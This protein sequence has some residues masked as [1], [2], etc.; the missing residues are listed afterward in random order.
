MGAVMMYTHDYH[1]F[2]PPN[3][4]SS[5]APSGHVWVIGHAAALPDAT[6][7][8]LLTEVTNNVLASYTGTNINIYKC[9][10]D[11]ATVVAGGVRVPTI[12]SISMS[13]AVGTVCPGSKSAGT[14][15]G[16][17]TLPSNG[18]WLDGNHTHTT[19]NPFRCFGKVSDFVNTA[20]TWVVMDE[21]QYSI[22]D[23]GFGHPGPWIAGATQNPTL[24][25]VDFPTINH[26][27]AGTIAYADGRSEIHKWKGLNYPA[28]GL[29]SNSVTA[30]TR[31]D[32]DWIA[33][34]TSQRAK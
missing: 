21:Y 4:D 19:G 10:A 15:S 7:V 26:G 18:P 13:Q 14:H 1:D 23:A 27:G 22:N 33:E 6:N 9:P 2:L 12:R 20:N 17:P 29:P 31:A 5:A 25:W 32:W 30:A 34:R 8:L 24:R 11:P 16:A 3:E 28:I